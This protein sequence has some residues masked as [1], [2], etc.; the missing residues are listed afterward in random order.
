MASEHPHPNPQNA[1]FVYSLLDDYGLSPAQ[2]RVLAHIARRGEAFGSIS[3]MSRVCRLHPHTVRCALRFLVTHRLLFRMKRPGKTWLYRLAPA[4]QWQPPTRIDSN[5]SKTHTPPSV[6]QGGGPKTIQG[7]P[8]ETDI[9]EGNPTKGNPL[10]EK[11]HTQYEPCG[12]PL[13]ET[14]AV[15]QAKLVGVPVDFARSEFNHMVAVNWLDGCHRHV[16]S[17]PHYIKQERRKEQSEADEG[18][19]RARL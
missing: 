8:C 10:K 1:I 19:S 13:N 3:N 7:Q 16:W 12:L 14:E 18:R 17:W 4:N 15:E 6:S 9:G 5:P 2:F 11:S